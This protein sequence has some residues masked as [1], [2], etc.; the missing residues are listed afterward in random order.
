MKA[1]QVFNSK[2][3]QA[4]DRIYEIQMMMEEMEAT[5]NVD[6]TNMRDADQLVDG[7]DKILSQVAK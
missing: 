2:M 1:Q 6:W 3:K 4:H 5:K 7:L